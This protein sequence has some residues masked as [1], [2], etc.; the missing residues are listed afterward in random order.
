MTLTG[1]THEGLSVPEWVLYIASALYI[2][3]TAYVLLFVGGFGILLVIYLRTRRKS[4]IAHPIADDQLLS[5]TIQL[6]IY[7][8]AHVVDRVLD[9]CA[10]MDYPPDKLHIQVL[11]DS[12]DQTTHVIRQKIRQLQRKPNA[13]HITHMHRMNRDGYKAGALAYGTRHITTDCVVIFD[14]DF[15]PE[16]DFLRRTMP[17]F[18]HNPQL[19]LIQTRWSHLNLDTNL[20]TRAQALSIDAHFAVEQV[21]R[22]RGQLP[23][24]MNGTGGIWRVAA[25]NDA[26]GWSPATLTEDLD[27]SYRAYM[28]GWDFL[29]LVD[30]AVPGE[31]PPLVQAYKTQ[32]ARWATGSTQCL[33]RH[34][35][36]LMRCPRCSPLKKLMGILHL[37]QYAIQPVILMLFLL[38]PV[39]LVS[40]MFRRLPDLTIVA[41]AGTIPPVMIALGQFEL[42]DDWRTRLLYFPVQ[43]MAAVA[44]VLNNSLA[45]FAAFTSQHEFIRTPKFR[46]TRRG[47]QW[48]L[49]QHPLKID[50]TTIG[51]LCLAVYAVCGLVIALRTFPALAPYLFSY[52]ASFTAFALWNIYQTWKCNRMPPLQRQFDTLPQNMA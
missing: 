39:L 26:G 32:Q 20:L 42:Y 45:V 15:V 1:I 40:G 23:M 12:T 34:L 50:L 49:R 9:A 48:R 47:Q 22:S 6:P 3:G 4:P 16:A 33:I 29:Y 28:R 37:S 18:N 13:P 46:I 19:G 24:A 52:A 43:F 51:E 30:V 31:L 44:L 17:Y 10:R 41:L 21:A 7:N 2:L 5:V 25:I 35:R 8:E 27:L 11:D 36:A 14:A 38:T